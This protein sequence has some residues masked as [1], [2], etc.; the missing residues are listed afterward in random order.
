[1]SKII[2]RPNSINTKDVSERIIIARKA[3]SSL[4]K[5][6]PNPEAFCNLEPYKNIS[7]VK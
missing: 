7:R 2:N 1:M 3:I 4:K 6:A 5:N